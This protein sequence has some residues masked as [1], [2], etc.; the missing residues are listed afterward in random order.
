M[1]HCQNNNCY[2]N[3]RD[4][5]GRLPEN[6]I[7]YHNSGLEEVLEICKFQRCYPSS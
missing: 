5:L 3:R 4:T 1:W 2:P 6:K 7:S